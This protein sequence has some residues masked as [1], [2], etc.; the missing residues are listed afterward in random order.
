[1]TWEG[2]D[3]G[4]RLEEEPEED[5]FLGLG[6]DFVVGVV[7]DST[8]SACVHWTSGDPAI[9]SVESRMPLAHFFEVIP[10]QA[11]TKDIPLYPGISS[12]RFL[13]LLDWIL[14]ICLFYD[15]SFPED[16]FSHDRTHP[17]EIC[18]CGAAY[19]GYG[20][21]GSRLGFDKHA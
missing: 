7:L 3:A 11:Y 13:A 10:S 6:S 2:A 1:M 5:G 21:R 8:S 12:W 19:I 15:L 18:V 17:C 20:S 14:L 4:Y 16:R 9:Y